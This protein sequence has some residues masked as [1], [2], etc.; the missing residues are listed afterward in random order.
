MDIRSLQ[1]LNRLIEMLEKNLKELRELQH[2]MQCHTES[3]KDIN[4]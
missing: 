4:L 1:W 3:I 2:K